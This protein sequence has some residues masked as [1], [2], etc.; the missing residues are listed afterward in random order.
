MQ[1]LKITLETSTSHTE[2]LGLTPSSAPHFPASCR[3]EPQEAGR[4]TQIPVT[5]LGDSGGLL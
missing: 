5:Y 4:G 2:G 3:H 1:Q